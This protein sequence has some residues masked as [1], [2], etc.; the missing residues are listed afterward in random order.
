M[1]IN[2]EALMR[3]M[4]NTVAHAVTQAMEAI[5]Q[6]TS[7]ASG[8]K[9]TKSMH[10][11]Y[12]RL[13]KFSSEE[14]GWKEWYYQFG[15]ATGAYDQK[16]A[17]VMESVE[18]M[19][20]TE[21]TTEHI[22]TQLEEAEVT[23]MDSTQG[24]LFSVLCLLT[25]GEANVLVRSCEDKNGY[26]AWKKLY[27]RFNP[28]TPASLTAAWREVVRPKKV[29]D[30]REAGKAI[31]T[32]EGKV[33]QLKKEH[34]EE[35][36]EGL[37]ASLLLE[38]LPDNAQMTVAQGMNSKKLEYETLKAKIK[39][40]ANVQIDYATPKPMDIGEMKGECGDEWENTEADYHV[41][42]VG[43]R[44][45]YRCGGAGHFAR[46]C[47][48]AKGKGKDGGDQMKGKGKGKGQ[49]ENP[50]G[51]G[52]GKSKGWS[53]DWSHKGDGKGKGKGGPRC[54]TCSGYGHRA[55]QCPSTSVR[56]VEHEEQEDEDEEANVGSVRR[57]FEVK[58]ADRWRSAS[59]EGPKTEVPGGW[60]PAAGRQIKIQN[61]F[62]ALGED[63]ET[64]IR[65]VE[66]TESWQP[67]G[68]AEIT[69]DS[70]ADESVCPKDW[71]KAFHTKWVPDE[72]K[73]RFRNASGGRM[74]HYGEKKVDFVAGDQEDV[75]RMHFQVSDVKRPLAAVCR[76]VERGNLVQFGPKAED[77]F[78]K[79]IATG[80]KISIRRKG[81]SYVM[82]V[83]M[84]K[85]KTLGEP[86]FTWQA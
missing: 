41:E 19:E 36:T 7:S 67:V 69:I 76:I 39:M 14:T 66:K 86:H 74:E 58:R 29:K 79:D 28:K 72:K 47:G 52:K 15:V 84:V 46:E 51:K 70:A 34:G 73:M 8:H 81:R 62:E 49:D 43:G 26:A 1:A 65:E 42:A 21:V 23:W 48:T 55:D 5:R 78:I 61:R 63:E 53:W 32:W 82:D 56:A 24:E 77:N 57:V 59:G 3:V 68:T 4:A 45:C 60:K 10:K 2:E 9:V 12:T 37:K 20:M 33:T 17:S 25:T 44:S 35:P 40:M 85:K 80:Q 22:K 16:T 13:E 54:W 18:S 6:T 75:M 31:D 30:M 50:K 27:D 71:M 38:M 64:W 11:Y 83:D